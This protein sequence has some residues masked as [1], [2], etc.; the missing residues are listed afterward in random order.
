M[1]NPFITGGWWTI[2][3]DIIRKWHWP[4]LDIKHNGGD[5]MLG[6]LCRQQNYKMKNFD[7][8]VGINAK[9][10]SERASSAPRRGRSTKLVGELYQRPS[11]NWQETLLTGTA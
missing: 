3:T 7:H 1:K 5:M 4:T 2:R 9:M 6:E 11:P 8:G 10:G